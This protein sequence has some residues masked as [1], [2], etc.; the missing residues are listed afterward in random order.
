MVSAEIAVATAMPIENTADCEVRGVIHFLQTDEILGYL[1]RRS[2]ISHGVVL[3]HD[4]A[5]PHT[6]RQIQ[7]LL[8]EQFH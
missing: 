5:R 8:L 4:N 2:K 6:A 1:S 3:L 7:T